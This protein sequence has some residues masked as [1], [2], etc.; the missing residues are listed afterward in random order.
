MPFKRHRAI[1]ALAIALLSFVIFALHAYD[2]AGASSARFAPEKDYGP[3]VYQDATGHIKGLSVDILAAVSRASGLQIDTLP[4]HNLAEILMLAERGE[5]DL[6]SSLR[7]TPERARYLDFSRPY[8]SVPAGLVRREGD[9]GKGFLSDLPGRAVAVGKGYAVEAYV[10]DKYP[11]VQWVTVPDD[12]TGLR[13]LLAGEV[14]GV[15][16]D[17]ASVTFS[18]REQALHGVQVRGP[19][20]FEY[21]LSFA[22]LKSRPD[23]GDALERGLRALRSDERDAVLQRWIDVDAIRYRDSRTE[24]VQK[25]AAVFGGL[26]VFMVGVALLRKRARGRAD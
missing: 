25:F 23:I 6:I 11:A 22:Y 19:V 1:N 21:P 20:G 14:Q 3:F 17:I 13:A 2:A 12:V 15:V 7:P 24:M 26:A 10:R 4:A 9:K 18:V 8:V 5:V 16:A